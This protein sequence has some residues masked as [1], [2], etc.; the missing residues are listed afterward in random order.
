[1]NQGELKQKA[2]INLVRLRKKH[3]LRQKQVVEA[4]KIPFKRYQSYEEAR[5]VPP[6]TI[7]LRLKAFYELNTIED[8]IT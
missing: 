3:D 8:L 4:C 7:L 2:A 5:A 1:M 6:I